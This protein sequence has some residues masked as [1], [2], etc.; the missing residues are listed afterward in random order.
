MHEQSE[1]AVSQFRP[2]PSAVGGRRS[3]LAVVNG[4]HI[5][6]VDGDGDVAADQPGL[7]PAVVTSDG[8]DVRASDCSLAMSWSNRATRMFCLSLKCRYTP[9]PTMPASSPISSIATA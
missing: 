8:Q 9:E 1:A 2:Q 3:G 5:A 7:G 4:E 6:I